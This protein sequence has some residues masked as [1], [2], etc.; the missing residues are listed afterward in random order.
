MKEIWKDIIDFEGLYQISNLGRVKRLKRKTSNG[1]T[2]MNKIM[3]PQ[4]NKK[5]YLHINLMKNKK[6]IAKS[7][8]R[9]V[10]EAF[11]PNPEN[12][13]EVN[14]IDGNKHNNCVNNL[15][16]VTHNEN[17]KHAYSNGLN[18][19]KKISQYDSE[20]KKIK[21]WNSTKEA[22]EYLKGDPS[23]IT[24]CCK[25]KRKSAYGF[26]WTYFN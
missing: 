19:C 20:G 26:I 10:A 6:V 21:D 24:K 22:A 12:K 2:L 11:V 3:T 4:K 5:D 15:E 1:Q 14:H 7:I 16:W 18:V 8:H 23:L 17:L 13:P 25:G 9:L